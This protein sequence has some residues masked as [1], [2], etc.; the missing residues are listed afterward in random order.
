MP[1]KIHVSPSLSTYL[2]TPYHLVQS[3]MDALLSFPFLSFLLIP[4]FSSYS[5]SLNILFFYLT[6]ST[7]ILSNSPLKVEIIGTLAIRLFFYIL[8]SFG[9]LL[10]DI[11]LPNVAAGIKEHGDGALPLSEGVGRRKSRW[12]KVSLTS[13]GNV[14]LAVAL[15]LGVELLFTE[16]FHIR[17]ALKVTT[18][19]PM[20]WG[21]AQHLFSGFLMREVCLI[22]AYLHDTGK[23]NNV[24][25]LGFDLCPS[26]IRLALSIIAFPPSTHGLA[27]L[28]VA[29]I[30]T[31]CTLRSSPPLPCPCLPTYVHSCCDIPFSLTYLLHVSCYCIS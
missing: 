9:F 31:N 17:S 28:C 12:W 15:Q 3:S 26:S 13:V 8:P 19:L 1:S 27:A 16:V 6:W 22:K 11:T 30:F 2:L 21:I 25:S 18:S 4:A 24:K 29:A 20:P 14:L 23:H 5:T 10:F 7:L